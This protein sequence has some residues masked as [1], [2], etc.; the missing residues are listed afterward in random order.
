MLE[1]SILFKCVTVVKAPKKLELI[2][3]I[4]FKY[5][6]LSFQTF[7]DECLPVS[8]FKLTKKRT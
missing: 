5:L 7:F 6:L 2:E 4:N 3:L 8:I 1:H